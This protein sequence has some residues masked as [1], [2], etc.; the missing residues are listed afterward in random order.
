MLP[1]HSLTIRFNRLMGIVCLLGLLPCGEA[2][3]QFGP[4]SPSVDPSL[5]P[6]QTSSREYQ[7][8]DAIE[9]RLQAA[10]IGLQVVDVPL[11][12]VAK[13]ITQR[14]GIPVRVDERG[15]EDVGHSKETP[16]TFALPEVAAETTLFLMLKEHDLVYTIDTTGIVITTPEEAESKL[17]TRFYALE[18][19]FHDPNPNY[20][21]FIEMLTTCIEP[22]SWE[23]LGGPA[24]LAPLRNGIV[25]SQTHPIHRRLQGLF[26]AL[27]QVQKSP[28]QKG[29]P[30]MMPTS[31]YAR[32]S[33]QVREQLRN[34]RTSITLTKAPIEQVIAAISNFGRIPMLVDRRALEDVGM[35]TDTPVDMKLKDVS[36]E[37]MLDVLGEKLDLTTMI[38]REVVI[39]TTPYEAER[40]L[41]TMLYPVKDFVRY[42][43]ATGRQHSKRAVWGEFDHLIEVITTTVEPE[44]WEEL[45]GPGSLYPEPYNDCLVVSQTH[46]VHRKVAEMLQQ[47]RAA[48]PT[49]RFRGRSSARQPAMP[50]PATQPGFAAVPRPVESIIVRSYSPAEAQAGQFNQEAFA[51]I[52]ERLKQVVARETWH[53]EAYFA[54]ATDSGI[55]VRHRREVQDT[56]ANYLA[57]QGLHA[58]PIKDEASSAER[59]QS[60][61]NASPDPP[62]SVP[63]SPP[64]V[65]S[66]GSGGGFF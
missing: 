46:K 33:Q 4:S 51:R 18:D 15:L 6:P 1:A 23:E 10:R 32:E 54:D 60:E 29:L 17:R 37:T 7:Q 20:D 14:T 41:E 35:S 50:A 57:S 43:P 11:D 45:G 64:P 53:D 19:I 13:M 3:A 36:I 42:D 59:F 47:V 8:I 63:A 12:Q 62:S 40:E 48:K 44:T 56:I 34:S 26:A 22:E 38:R 55:F 16:I 31:P 25:V 49:Q 30:V 58:P 24:S 5:V 39:L 9:K 65:N 66:E 61:S 21:V 28:Q 52:A 2:V 27:R